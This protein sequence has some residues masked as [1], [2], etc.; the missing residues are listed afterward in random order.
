M[1]SPKAT[2]EVED[3][4]HAHQR[5]AGRCDLQVPVE[6]ENGKATRLALTEDIGVGGLFVATSS[7][8]RVGEEIS[9]W[10][11]LPGHRIALFVDAEIR[12]VRENAAPGLRHGARG[13]GLRFVNPSFYVAEAIQDFL[14]QP[15]SSGV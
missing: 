3:M 4:Q 8:G 12:W 13:M 9:L 15:G 14:R 11:K 5:R 7:P 1:D 10:F 6:I 2:L